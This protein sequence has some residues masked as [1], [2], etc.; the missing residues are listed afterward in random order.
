MSTNNGR[1]APAPLAHFTIGGI[2]L[3]AFEA[4]SCG[5][6]TGCSP[7]WGGDVTPAE[8]ALRYL[9][10]AIPL[11]GKRPP[12]VGW[13]TWDATRESIREWWTAHPDAN[14][15]IRCGSGLAVLD[16]DPRHGGDAA[17]T[18]LEG[19]HGT[20]P[21]T[22]TVA[23]GGDGWHFYFKAPKGLPSRTIAPGLE[24]KAE[25]RQVVAPP[26]IHPE[27]GREYVW[28]RPLVESDMA[29]LPGWLMPEPA[30]VRYVRGG[31]HVHGDD[32]LRT[33]PATE[34]VPAL[35]GSAV[36][37]DLKAE[38]PFHEDWRPSLHCYR[39]PV[40][41]WFCFQCGR[42]GSIYDLGAFL[43]GITPRGADFHRL[44]QRL[45]TELLGAVA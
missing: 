21:V 3:P 36:G 28:T 17:L 23:T 29:V 8:A 19:M 32:Y 45:A 18:E 2:P 1:G 30:P 5:T 15:G 24:L 10:R 41:G 7:G 20:L 16:V 11:T 44:R 37:P 31:D 39:D 25:G 6:W 13:R 42:G 9:P 40:R 12:M 26:S 4:L 34:Y 27:T 14:V 35:T 38:C 43:Y 22:P 33:I